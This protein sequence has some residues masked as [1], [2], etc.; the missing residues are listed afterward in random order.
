MTKVKVRLSVPV[1]IVCVQ[2]QT[3]IHIEN[4]T[5]SK[6]N[7]C[8]WDWNIPGE[9]PWLVTAY[10]LASDNLSLTDGDAAHPCEMQGSFCAWR[11]LMRDDDTLNVVSR[12]LGPCMYTKQNRK[13]KLNDLFNIWHD[14]WL[15]AY[16]LLLCAV[17]KQYILFYF[18]S[19]LFAGLCCRPGTTC[20]EIY[21]LYV[22][23]H[24]TLVTGL[25]RPI[26]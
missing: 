19:L 25:Y 18:I 5:K 16:Y 3:C 21:W 13:L 11:G 20:E 26:L 14:S 24:L 6:K 2:N 15:H 8:C 9:I 23:G 12:C 7:F 4:R 17:C 10:I 1:Q 22:E